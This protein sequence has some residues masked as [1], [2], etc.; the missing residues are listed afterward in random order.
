[1]ATKNSLSQRR[2]KWVYTT[3][4]W[5]RDTGHISHTK[6]RRRLGNT[7]QNITR[8]TRLTHMHQK[9]I[10]FK[11]R[12]IFCAAKQL[13][14]G[15]IEQYITR[16]QQLA[17]NWIWRCNRK[18]YPRSNKIIMFIIKN[19]TKSCIKGLR[20]QLLTDPDLTLNKLAQIPSTN[21]QIQKKNQILSKPKSIHINQNCHYNYKVSL[22]LPSLQTRHHYQQ[23]IK[24]SNE[25][26]DHY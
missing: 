8:N 12:L 10:P 4:G 7:I 13:V 24:L 21:T 22:V 20:K 3:Y 23:N 11:S 18:Q 9:N 1:M 16:L 5:P 17:Q 6:C 26:L 2:K 15:S 19:L 25:I 14:K